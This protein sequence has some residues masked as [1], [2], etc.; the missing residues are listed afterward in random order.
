[1]LLLEN[2]DSLII[3]DL[4][5]N[6]CKLCGKECEINCQS[7]DKCENWFHDDCNKFS[8]E[9]LQNLVKV[10][11]LF[12]KSEECLNVNTEKDKLKKSVEKI[13]TKSITQT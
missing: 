11:S 6:P 12:W 3:G 4:F 10:K 13:K 5:W 1:M 8:T 9:V 7:C 2:C